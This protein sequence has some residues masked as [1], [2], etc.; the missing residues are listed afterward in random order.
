MP[1]FKPVRAGEST[2]AEINRILEMAKTGVWA[3][4]N[5]F[6]MV[7]H[8]P[9][10]LKAMIPVFHAIFNEGSVPPYLKDLMRIATGT[11]WGCEY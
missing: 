3:D 5:L 7:A 8:R 4:P 9:A 10:F 11:E 2:D 1:R 6:G